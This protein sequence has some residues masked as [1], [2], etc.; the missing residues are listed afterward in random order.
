MIETNKSLI[1]ALLCCILIISAI[2]TVPAQTSADKTN[3]S[4]QQLDAKVQE[5][6]NQ[7]TKIGVGGDITI[8]GNNRREFYGSILKIEDETVS[9][10]EIDQK[11]IVKIKYQDIKKVRKDYGTARNRFGNRIRP[12]R[13]IIALAIVGALLAI[14]IIILANAKD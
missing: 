11:V 14:P 7:V 1:A 5:I 4:S 8:I 6:K 12:R 3:N 2:V 13:Q 10:N 9:I